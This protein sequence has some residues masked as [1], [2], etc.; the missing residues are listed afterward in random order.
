MLDKK[1][2]SIHAEFPIPNYVPGTTGNQ[3]RKTTLELGLKEREML[4]KKLK[5]KRRTDLIRN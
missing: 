4:E 5:D 1:L 2:Q 3:N